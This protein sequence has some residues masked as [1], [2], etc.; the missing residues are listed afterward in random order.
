MPLIIMVFQL[1]T[2][3]NIDAHEHSRVGGALLADFPSLAQGYYG[4]KPPEEHFSRAG[5]RL[6]GC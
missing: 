4:P 5:G 3:V 6:L 1:F 2:K